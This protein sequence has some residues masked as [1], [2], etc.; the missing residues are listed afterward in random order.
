M[1]PPA[2]HVFPCARCGVVSVNCWPSEAPH[3]LCP[4]CLAEHRRER[5]QSVAS[6]QRPNVG[7]AKIRSFRG[8][9]YRMVYR[10]DHPDT[11]GNGWMMEHRLVMESMLGRRLAPT[12][13]VHHIDENG[14]NND[15]ANLVLVDSKG[16]HLAAHHSAEGVRVRMA[17]YPSC[18]R[19]GART[20]YGSTLCWKCWSVSQTCPVCGRPNRK[21][22]RRDICHGCYKSLRRKRAHDALRPVS[23]TTSPPNS[24]V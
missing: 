22:A 20:E 7:T 23:A 1:K 18:E 3:R 12:E 21:M 17:G 10:P 15:P 6:G 16:A 19:C 4:A 11:P 8:R 14:L 24:S 5:G 2:H 9:R 13:V